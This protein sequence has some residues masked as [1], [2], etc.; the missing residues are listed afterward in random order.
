MVEKTQEL[1]FSGKTRWIFL[2][3]LAAVTNFRFLNLLL[4]SSS[5]KPALLP[6]CLGNQ[7]TEYEE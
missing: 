6:P 1:R 3:I 4:I 7:K 2:Y 5:S